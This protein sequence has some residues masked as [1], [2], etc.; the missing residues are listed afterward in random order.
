[1]ALIEI[2]TFRLQPDVVDEVFIAAD[3]VVQAEFSYQQPGIVR[4][5]IARATDGTWLIS[6]IWASDDDAQAAHEAFA[7]SDLGSDFLALIDEATI[8]VRSFTPAGAA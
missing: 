8:E 1:M 5:T 3:A 2:M 4:R 7:A 6:T